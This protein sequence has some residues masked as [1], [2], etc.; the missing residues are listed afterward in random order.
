M[1][2]KGF[3][4]FTALVAVMIVFLGVLVTQ[5]MIAGERTS[6]Q[7]ISGAQE[8]AQML[9]FAS[10]SK[11]DAIQ[12]FNWGLRASFE[13][14]FTKDTN[15]TDGIP[16]EPF[17]IKNSFFDAGD[18]TLEKK[19][20]K[21]KTEFV[22]QNFGDLANCNMGDPLNPESEIPPDCT[23]R[24]FVEF[25]ANEIKKALRNQNCGS[26]PTDSCALREEYD[27]KIE[28]IDEVKFIKI[29][30]YVF[31]RSTA[32]DDFLDVSNCDG[33]WAGCDGGGFYINL[34]FSKPNEL[35]QGG[36]GE[37]VYEALPKIVV[38][39]T[40]TCNSDRSVCGKVLKQPI[41]PRGVLRVFVPTRI[42]KALAG[43][44]E[45]INSQNMFDKRS[46][47]KKGFKKIKLGVCDSSLVWLYDYP[48]RGS[49]L[50]PC[51]SHWVD[52]CYPRT[53]FE[54]P[55]TIRGFDGK[56]CV[57]QTNAVPSEM[58]SSVGLAGGITYNPYDNASMRSALNYYAAGTVLKGIVN[59]TNNAAARTI[60]LDNNPED[61]ELLK[62]PGGGFVWNPEV[63]STA[64]VSRNVY[65]NRGGSWVSRCQKVSLV[66]GV[67]VFQDHMIGLSSDTRFA[68]GIYDSDYLND[69]AS[70]DENE[71]LA[72]CT[73]VETIKI[74]N[75]RTIRTIAC[76]DP[77]NL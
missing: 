59:E 18:T 75:L 8:E 72:A 32:H 69:F 46:E 5:S 35:G 50:P 38:K 25:T 71:R 51:N 13:K 62:T 64:P 3:T 10:F 58:F 49:T 11:N 65:F 66:K 12:Q 43:A 22:K 56:V 48:P 4:L 61:F 17:Y 40:D 24:P 15:P 39:K 76:T 52:S 68:I 44:N 42:F 33:T 55:Q 2:E 28:E 54:T 47:F 1:G 63:E 57:G 73:T 29:L 70:G 19:F 67:F 27:L 16:D 34:D 74:I 60:F 31:S 23:S 6:V 30:L 14:Y 36:V 45:I 26:T 77:N 37:E 9:D 53:S 20:G 7:I 41:F 21:I